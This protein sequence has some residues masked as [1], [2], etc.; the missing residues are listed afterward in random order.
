MR[1]LHAKS[2]PLNYRASTALS[3]EFAVDYSYDESSKKSGQDDGLEIAK[4][5]ISQDIVSALAKKGITKLFP[6]QVIYHFPLVC[7][8]CLM[9]K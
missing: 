9:R 5:G 1:D 3:A 8:V 6:I 4:L 7:S 2:G